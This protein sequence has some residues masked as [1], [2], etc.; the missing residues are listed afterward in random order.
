MTDLAV[1]VLAGIIVA[2][3]SGVA[4]FLIRRAA[5]QRQWVLPGGRPAEKESYL[6]LNGTWH[7]Y[8]ISFDPFNG[9]DPIWFQGTQKLQINKNR[10]TG[11][12]ELI[13]HPLGSLHFILK[14]EVRAGRMIITD[15][16][17]EDE[18]EFATVV[19]SNVRFHT[20]LFGIWT[21]LDNKLRPIAAPAL[22]SR[23]ERNV[24]ELNKLLAGSP[25]LLVAVNPRKVLAAS[26]TST[27]GKDKSQDKTQI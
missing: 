19:Y 3:L 1:Q 9:R 13:N 6:H 23:E 12:T 4:G 7:L 21:G 14:G 26:W 16:C 22:L 24:D 8:W 27:I 11:T 20:Q 18:T 5:D 25:L 15:V 2:A 17:V 10:V